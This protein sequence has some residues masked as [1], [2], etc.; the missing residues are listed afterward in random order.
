MRMILVHGINQEGKSSEVILDEWL[1]VLRE[2][3]A[4]QDVNPL[5]QLSRID[6]AFYGDRLSELAEAPARAVAVA[7]GVDGGSDDFDL[8]AKDALA[9]MGIKMGATFEDYARE[10]GD[11]ADPLGAGV[12]KKWLKAVARVIERV[13]PLKGKVA[14]RILAQAHAYIRNDYIAAEIDKLVRPLFED[15]EPAIV[16]SHSLGTIVSYKM[17]R[18]FAKETRPRACPL[19]LTL[20]SPLGIDVV[21][22]GFKLPRNRPAHVERW[23]N[24]ADPE[25]FVSLRVALTS[26]SDDGVSRNIA[27]IENGYDDPHCIAGYL[28]DERVAEEIRCA[29]LGLPVPAG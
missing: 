25:D 10:S 22:K 17:L 4:K 29:I 26:D 2:H 18:T 19:F 8:F 7:Q 1:P 6:A 27:D 23:V 3:F 5:A 16:V 24:G 11:I 12:H 21:R 20:G 13:S 28:A 15:D 14:L 9:E